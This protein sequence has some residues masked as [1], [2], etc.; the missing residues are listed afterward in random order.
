MRAAW[1]LACF[2]CFATVLA[3]EHLEPKLVLRVPLFGTVESGRVN[4]GWASDVEVDQGNEQVKYDEAYHLEFLW[5]SETNGAERV[6]RRSDM[7]A[8]VKLPSRDA[9][10]HYEEQMLSALRAL[11]PRAFTRSWGGY[12]K[13]NSPFV[14]AQPLTPTLE[15]MYGLRDLPAPEYAYELVACLS[16]D[17]G[18]QAYSLLVHTGSAYSW[19]YR[20]LGPGSGTEREMPVCESLRRVVYAERDTVHSLKTAAD[21]YLLEITASIAVRSSEQCAPLPPLEQRVEED[22]QADP[23]VPTGET[24]KR[25]LIFT[26]RLPETVY[27]PATFSNAKAVYLSYTATVRR[28][29]FGAAGEMISDTELVGEINQVIAYFPCEEGLN[30]P[31]PDVLVGAI[32]EAYERSSEWIRGEAQASRNAVRVEVERALERRLQS[33]RGRYLAVVCSRVSDFAE[34]ES[35]NVYVDY[36]E[37]VILETGDVCRAIERLARGEAEI[38]KSSN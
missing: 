10:D 24:Q 35:G 3:D 36:D 27:D 34:F 16:D 20:N 23:D 17:N 26:A 30:G 7:Y 32:V 14:V 25:R 28:L 31:D 4:I 6:L 33:R 8:A 15:R 13:W 19:T 9:R 29:L 18:E 37:A 1:V 12:D 22:V 11:G 5:I 21:M 2:T 38:M